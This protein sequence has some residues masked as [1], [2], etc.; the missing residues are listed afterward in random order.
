MSIPSA[1]NRLFH[2]KWLGPDSESQQVQLL[3]ILHPPMVLDIVLKTTKGS[4]TF[5]CRLVNWILLSP[6]EFSACKSYEFDVFPLQTCKCDLAVMPP[7]SHPTGDAIDFTVMY[8][9]SWY[10]IVIVLAV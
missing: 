10:N 4:C 3:L 5:P 2:V 8:T 1:S 9:A 7:P 6:L